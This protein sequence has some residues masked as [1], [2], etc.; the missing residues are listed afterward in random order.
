MQG[1]SRKEGNGFQSNNEIK[2]GVSRDKSYSQS[3]GWQGPL[4]NNVSPTPPSMY[5]N[6]SQKHGLSDATKLFDQRKQS[7]GKG[8]ASGKVMVAPMNFQECVQLLHYCRLIYKSVCIAN[9]NLRN[10][11]MKMV[12]V[13][14]NWLLD[15]LDEIN[16]KIEIFVKF[17]G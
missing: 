13:Y 11:N 4:L 3:N 15:M 8:M 2:K 14:S 10:L 7:P 9:R 17:E 1:S 12:D 16:D 5:S 6:G